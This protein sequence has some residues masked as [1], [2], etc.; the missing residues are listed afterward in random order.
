[1]K[2]Y[3]DI[4]NWSRKDHFHFFKQFEEPFFGV[5]VPIDCTIAYKKAKENRHS[6]FLSY[7][8]KAL[9]AVNNIECFRYRISGEQIYIYDQIDASPTIGRSDGTFGFSYI[10]Y[11]DN[12]EQFNVIAK[13]EIERVSNSIGLDPATSGENVVH[14]SSLPWLD[15][16]SFSHARSFTFP[17]SAPKIS[18]GK[19][20]ETDG[21]KSISVSIHVHHGLMDGF[22]VGQFVKKFQELMNA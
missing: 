9:V 22:H 4:D 3:L 17:D 20:T 14:F 12:F 5:C 16:T 2:Q 7:L 15:F 8:H 11:H 1:M 13:K 6:F 10:K 19:M 18:F 21:K